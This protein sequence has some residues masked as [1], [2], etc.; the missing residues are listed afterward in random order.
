MAFELDWDEIAEE[1]P[2]LYSGK[3]PASGKPHVL[4]VEEDPEDGFHVEHTHDC[5]DQWGEVACDVAWNEDWVGLD[6]FF[7]RSD[8]EAGDKTTDG[9]I[10]GRYWVEAWSSE[11][12]CHAYGTTEYDHGIALHYPEEAE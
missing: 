6:T 8:A 3:Q 5:L 1:R 11:Y 10:P 12:Y 2:I 7:H 9:L 4:V